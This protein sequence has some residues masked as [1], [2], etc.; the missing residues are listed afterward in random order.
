MDNTVP[1]DDKSAIIIAQ[2][3]YNLVRLVQ[4]SFGDLDETDKDTV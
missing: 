1:F 3:A 4:P 2:K